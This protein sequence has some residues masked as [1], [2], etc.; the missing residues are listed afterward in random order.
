MNN[1]IVCICGILCTGQLL[2]A[3]PLKPGTFLTSEGIYKGTNAGVARELTI[4]TN[5]V[6][7]A[8]SSGQQSTSAGSVNWVA[9]P[10]WF[11]YVADDMRVWAY[12]GDRFL[13]LLESDA[14][15]GRS[16]TS[17][18]LQETPPAAVLKK[19][20]K[21]MRK[22]VSEHQLAA[23]KPGGEAK[24]VRPVGVGTN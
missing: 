23:P 8:A 10:H 7:L 12:N 9:A 19:L 24:G 6:W 17:D 20:P 11:V 14:Q 1:L 13:I 4:Q 21:A 5:K 22:L 18:Y 15:R 3:E 2:A 16:V